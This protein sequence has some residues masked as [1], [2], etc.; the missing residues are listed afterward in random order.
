MLGSGSS[1]PASAP[2]ATHEGG[3]PDVFIYSAKVVCVPALGKAKPALV[4]GKYKTAVNVHNPSGNAVNVEKWITL[5]PPQGQD[6]VT[7]DHMT[8]V[9]GGWEAFDVD[10]KH[11][12]Q[13]F[14]LDGAT[15]PGGKGFFVI[16]SDGP[17]DVVAVYTSQKIDAV[18]GG[19]GRSM[20]T[21]YIEPRIV[22]GSGALVN[23]DFEAGVLSPWRLTNIN[24]SIQQ[25]VQTY[26]AGPITTNLP[27]AGGTHAYKVRP[28]SQY[29]DA[30][31]EQTVAGVVRGST[32]RLDVDLAA[33]ELQA[34]NFNLGTVTAYLDGVEVDSH[35]YGVPGDL[36][37][38]YA[39]LT[40]FAV[41]DGFFMTVRVVVNRPHS[42]GTANPLHLIDNIDLS[43]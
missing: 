5:S 10:C 15:V 7:G 16:V 37:P 3:G 38:R 39:S 22:S 12:A 11:M 13:D 40:G 29:P 28:G 27:Y 1:G 35:A 23:G 17:L 31:V 43:C 18:V 41:A 20:D 24:T 33:Q 25:G 9:L 21:E 14:G 8:E 30:G 34:G 4:S 26:P 19:V 42:A 32:C 2:A 36:V 6:V